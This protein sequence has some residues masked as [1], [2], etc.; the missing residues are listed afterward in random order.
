[1]LYNIFNILLTKCHCYTNFWQYMEIT[2][3]CFEAENYN[4]MKIGET[5]MPALGTNG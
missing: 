2:S 4:V 5:S 1:M 3:L